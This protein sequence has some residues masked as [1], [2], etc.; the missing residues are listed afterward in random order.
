MMTRRTINTSRPKLCWPPGRKRA[1]RS[2]NG[3]TRSL[4]TMVASATLAT[5][6]MPVAADRPPIKTASA[7]PRKPSAIGNAST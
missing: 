7:R 4:L 6:T 5:M 2:N 1:E 3:I